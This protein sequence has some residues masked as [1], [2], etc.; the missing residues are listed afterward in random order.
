M[1]QTFSDKFTITQARVVYGDIKTNLQVHPGSKDVVMISGVDTI[2]ACILNLIKTS[3]YERP[4]QPSLGSYLSTLMFENMDTHTLS[5]ARQM[6]KDTVN[7]YEPRATINDVTISP[8]PDENGIYITIVYSVLN[9]NTPIT[10]D[11]I[12]NR[13]R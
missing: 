12:L 13:V 9:N 5:F 3:P 4:F 11:L 10:I 2:K 7:L 1:A 8:A 6:I